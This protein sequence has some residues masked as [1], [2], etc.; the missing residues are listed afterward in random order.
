MSERPFIEVSVKCSDD[1]CGRKNKT[2]L[3]YDENDNRT[4][5]PYEWICK[6]G[7]K[8]YANINIPKKK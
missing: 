7:R 5:I 4:L 6:C 2:K 3:F 8:H 1:S